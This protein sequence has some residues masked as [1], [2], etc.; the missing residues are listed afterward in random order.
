MFE[1]YTKLN[2]TLNLVE[3]KNPKITFFTFCCENPELIVDTLR[4]LRTSYG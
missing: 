1:T 2:F 4:V 3:C